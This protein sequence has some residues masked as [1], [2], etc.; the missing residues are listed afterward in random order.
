M[1]LQL[2]YCSIRIEIIIIFW[3]AVNQQAESY[4]WESILYT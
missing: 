1:K 2:L 3:S 4:V